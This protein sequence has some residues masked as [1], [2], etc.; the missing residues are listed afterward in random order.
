MREFLARIAE[1]HRTTDVV[2]WN[3]SSNFRMPVAL[4]FQRT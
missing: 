2:N 4:W 3:S 1:F